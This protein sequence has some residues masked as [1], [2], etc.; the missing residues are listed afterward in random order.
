MGGIWK[1]NKLA[2]TA[3]SSA[4]GSESLPLAFKETFWAPSCL[5]PQKDTQRDVSLAPSS[6]SFS[7]APS[8][9]FCLVIPIPLPPQHHRESMCCPWDLLWTDAGRCYIMWQSLCFSNILKSSFF[10]RRNDSMSPQKFIEFS[11]LCSHLVLT[12]PFLLFM[13]CRGIW[14][15]NLVSPFWFWVH[16]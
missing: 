12:L 2:T 9:A 16:Q 7:M 11:L 4:N 13:E 1:C 15:E 10:S 5:T 14:Q 3:Q 6:S 8:P